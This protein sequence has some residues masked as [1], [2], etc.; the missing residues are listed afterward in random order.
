MTDPD[1]T[2]Q[3]SDSGAS[4]GG[5][6]STRGEALDGADARPDDLFPGLERSFAPRQWTAASVFAA[7]P[8]G[9]NEPSDAIRAYVEPRDADLPLEHGPDETH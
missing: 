8:D 2:D 9:E 5:E 3:N 6:V 4:A 1:F 7:A